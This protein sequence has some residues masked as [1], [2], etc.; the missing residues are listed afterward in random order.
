MRVTLVSYGS[1]GDIL[2]LVALAVGLR[3]AGHQVVTVGDQAGS[4][5]AT[6]HGLEFHALEGSL[7]ETMEPGQPSA[8]AVDA[9]HFTWKSLR[10]YDAHDRARLGLIQQVAEGSDVVVGM[11]VAHYHALAAAREVGARPVLGVL[12][13]LAPTH[14]MAPAGVGMPTLPRVLRRPAGRAVQLAGW[15]NA[16]RPLNA[17]RRELGQAPITDPTRD[18]YTLCAWSPSL[19]PQPDD[20]PASRFAV[21]GRWQLPASPWTPDPAL[22]AF[23][24]AGEPPVHVGFGSMRGFSGMGRLLDALV[25]GLTPRRIILAADPTA[26]SDR[27][28]PENVHLSTGFVPHDWLFPRC[29]AVVHHC[30]AGTAHEAAASGVPS[31]PVPISMDQPFWAD[32]LHRLG[33]ASAPLDPR[34]PSVERV[35][36]AVATAESHAVRLRATQLA[37]RLAPEDGVRRAVT[38]LEELATSRRV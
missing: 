11:P 23:L 29:A 4:D 35:R 5:V 34:K 28:L 24:D 37:Q 25:A 16:R 17:A 7:R 14:A 30:G 12:Q 36:R 31:V 21:T 26:L 3:A 20:W 15:L 22:S 18:V 33:V 1:T 9:G 27:A 19:V 6:R 13:P 32:R 38:R 2:P 10:N 8:L